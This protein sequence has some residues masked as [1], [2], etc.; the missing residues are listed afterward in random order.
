MFWFW[1][2]ISSL[3]P[4]NCFLMRSDYWHHSIVFLVSISLSF[5]FQSPLVSC[6]ASSSLPPAFT[7]SLIMCVQSHVLILVW[8]QFANAIQLLSFESYDYFLV[9]ITIVKLFT[10]VLRVSNHMYCFLYEIRLLISFIRLRATQRIA[11]SPTIVDPHHAADN[12]ITYY[13][14]ST[15]TSG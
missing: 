13:R 2:E 3:T 1:Y 4:F 6:L 9:A 11:A 7:A 8:D 10:L 15:Q 5:L 14:R 12:R